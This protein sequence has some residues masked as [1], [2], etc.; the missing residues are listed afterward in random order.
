MHY[1]IDESRLHIALF[2][3]K[4]DRIGKKESIPSA[5][6]LALLITSS[7]G[8]RVGIRNV[9]DADWVRREW[10]SNTIFVSKL[11]EWYQQ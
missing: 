4:T 6:A 9:F 10:A 11:E 1:T 7:I 2:I 3:K 8:D 5:L